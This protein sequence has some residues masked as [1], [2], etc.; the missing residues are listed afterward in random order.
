MEKSSAL[1][2]ALF[3]VSLLI[4]I[5][6]VEVGNANPTTMS[7]FRIT[8]ESPKDIT[9][10]STETIFL[11]I[12]VEINE[13]DSGN[14]SYYYSL[15]RNDYRNSSVKFLET[16]GK[17]FGEFNGTYYVNGSVVLP[18]FPIGNHK[19]TVFRGVNGSNGLLT[20]MGTPA[21][22]NFSIEQAP[23]PMIAILAPIAAIAVLSVVL[24]VYFRR[25]KGKP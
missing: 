10:Y 11:N 15:D 3:V 5:Q 22:A 6:A 23:F 4:G 18:S 8:I 25:R 16:K 12:T 1:F 19:V 14:T 7:W 9:Y 21:V 13:I 20:I 17:G 2:T 24:L